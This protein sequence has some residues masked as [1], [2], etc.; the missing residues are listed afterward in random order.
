VKMLSCK[1]MEKLTSQEQ[2]LGIIGKIQFKL[3]LMICKNCRCFTENMNT[4]NTSIK[5]LIQKKTAIDDKKIKKLE[6]EIKEKFT[7]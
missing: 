6:E 3:H 5:S 7:P 1:D 2:K 4:L